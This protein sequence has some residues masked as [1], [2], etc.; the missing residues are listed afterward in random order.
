MPIIRSYTNAFEIVD[1]TEELAIVPNSPTLLNDIGLF[2]EVSLQTKTVT[3]EETD[4]SIA[5]LVD[6]PW[7]SK[8]LANKDEVRRI[9]SYPV[10][11]FPIVDEVLP[12]DINGVRAYGKQD[13][14]ATEAEVMARKIA[15]IQD[16]ITAVKEAARWSTLTTG[17]IYTPGGSMVAGNF[18][19][20][21]GITQTSVDFLL[22]TAGTD[23]VAKVEA[24]IAAMQD[25]NKT[26]QR[27]SEIVGYCSPEFFAKLIAHAKVQTAY[28]YYTATAG[29][30]VLRNRAGNNTG[31]L[32]R[33]FFFGG[34][35][36]IEV[37][38]LLANGSRPIPANEA[39][40]LPVGLNESFVTYYAPAERFGLVNTLA[41]KAYLWTFKSPKGT[42]IDIEAE[43]N[44]INVLRRPQL[45]IKGT[46]SN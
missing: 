46:T 6:R 18:F 14:L 41:E 31:S 11:H 23:V 13:A 27:V 45:V 12:A 43:T 10:A 42:N 28:T 5:L 40:F 19:T 15:R 29:Q 17:N 22:G 1:Y 9:R 38:Q 37:R 3:F 4:R 39:V 8:P 7:G 20:D 32:N 26:G 21:F 35:R 24:I 25:N 16:G 33:E 36:F 2:S 34:I 30:E 44:F